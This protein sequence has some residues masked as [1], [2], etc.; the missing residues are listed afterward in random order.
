MTKSR[1]LNYS[2]F[3]KSPVIA[4]LDIGSSKICCL[5]A[6]YDKNNNISIIGAGFQESKGF[7]SGVMLNQAFK[8][9]RF[10]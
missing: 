3:S 5:I 10:E 7:I 6:K 4:A 9:I 2:T 8:Y 1:W